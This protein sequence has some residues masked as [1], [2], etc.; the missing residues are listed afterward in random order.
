[1]IKR[2]NRCV[3]GN[4]HKTILHRSRGFIL[5]FCISALS[6]MTSIVAAIC[7]FAAMFSANAVTAGNANW[8]LQFDGTD[9][10]ASIPVTNGDFDFDHTLTI[11]A[12][13]KPLSVTGSGY[14]R[15]I[16]RG[17]HE[18]PPPKKSGGWVMFLGKQ[19]RSSWGLGVCLPRCDDAISGAGNIQANQWQHL[20]GVYDGTHV[21]IYRNGYF[22]AMRDH[23]HSGNISHIS[24]VL[25]GS[26]KTSF[27]GLIDEVR[28]WN[29]VRTQSQ[30]QANMNIS[31]TGSEPGL[32]GYWRLDEGS[33]QT[34][35]DSTGKN[36]GR[37]GS[38]TR[39]DT[40]DPIWVPSDLPIP[41]ADD[42]GIADVSDNC[43]NTFNPKQ[44]D[45]DNDTIGDVC[46]NC[47]KK[48]GEVCDEFSEQLSK[49]LKE[50]ASY[51][52]GE[53]M[54]FKVRFTNQSSQDMTTIRP[55]CYNTF[56]SVD[57][58]E[59]KFLA[60]RSRSRMAYG[61][62]NDTVDIPAEASVSVT[63]DI[64][65]MYD[66]LAWGSGKYNVVATYANYF[67]DPD[68]D[69]A[70][71]C[72]EPNGECYD[73]WMGSVSSTART[74]SVSGSPVTRRSADVTFIPNE[75]Q[76]GWASG[77][78]PITARISNIEGRSVR[79]VDL[80]TIRLNG[81]APIISD[82]DSISNGA[83]TVQFV[84][85]QALES[86][87]TPHPGTVWPTVQGSVGADYFSGSHLVQI[88]QPKT[89]KKG[90]L[91]W[92]AVIVLIALIVSAPML[93]WN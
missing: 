61:I 41:D 32:V 62:P 66:P 28:V 86:L 55:D 88:V 5:K 26:W 24:Y 64:S 67:Q 57:D 25:L 76:T 44:A 73:L 12:W 37:L 90:L 71:N 34:I 53:P 56:F 50:S 60:P 17:A 83:V 85:S 1:M 45:R 49:P 2:T 75:W 23:C 27:N 65:E 69:N 29:V 20:A 81:T 6:K 35:A 19:A 31:L 40:Y 48:P 91:A 18:E 14:Y 33:G 77:G 54:W 10:F 80:S 11:E 58:G 87:G 38:T 72:I 74:I 89:D 52:P 93:N 84:A 39:V 22:V 36:N 82:S 68:I 9:D 79:E 4:L 63:C 30:I 47:P 42:D 15:G 8:A 70:G 16:V 59:G 13:V 46:D 78:P 3:E 92:I 51:S 43:P 21:S 7:I